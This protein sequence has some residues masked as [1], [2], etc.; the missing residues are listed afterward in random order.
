MPVNLGENKNTLLVDD[1]ANIIHWTDL[2]IRTALLFLEYI[3][4]SICKFCSILILSVNLWIAK[5]SEAWF[6]AEQLMRACRFY[7]L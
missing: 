1:A 7:Q 5:R 2:F 6:F 3:Y 4:I